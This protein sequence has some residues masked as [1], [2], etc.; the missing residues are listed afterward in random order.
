M[1]IV[2]F[3]IDDS[4]I[5]GALEDGSERL[6]AL[7]GDPL[8]QKTEPSGQLYTLEEARLLS[9]VIPR[10]KV[11]SCF[12]N[13]PLNCEEDCGADSVGV[14]I[15]Q[16]PQVAIKPNTAVIGP[17]DPIA[18]PAWG[19][20]NTQIFVGLAAVVKTICKNVLSDDLDQVIAGWTIGLDCSLGK[21]KLGACQRRAWDTSAPL[22][23]WIVVDPT[24]DPDQVTFNAQV[25]G[26][27]VATANSSDFSYRVGDAFAKVS[28]MMTL[29]PGDVVIVGG[30]YLPEPLRPGQRIQAMVSGIG[31]LENL[32]VSASR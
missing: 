30:M 32:V 21:E 9:P 23:P 2:R 18:I 12:Q 14:E 5:Y 19:G 20:G 17:D 28:A 26:V 22:G 6:V 29:L 11:V 24:F 31:A 4:L 13:Q 7:K 27:E 10:S 16:F 15:T 1:K 3:R 25:D 8:F